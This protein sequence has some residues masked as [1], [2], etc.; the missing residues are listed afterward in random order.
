T[1]WVDGLNIGVIHLI[2]GVLVGE[3]EARTARARTGWVTT[4]QDRKTASGH[5]VADG[6]VVVALVHQIGN[7][8]DG[9]R[10]QRAI[11][12]HRDST[13]VGGEVNG[14]GAFGA[15]IVALGDGGRVGTYAD[16]VVI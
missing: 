15:D 3:L 8:I 5:A 4:L 16:S 1:T 2:G 9:T 7:G 13:L 14:R 12:L 10:C 11:A 6:V